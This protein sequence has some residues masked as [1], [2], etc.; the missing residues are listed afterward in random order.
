MVKNNNNKK[1][2]NIKI[3]SSF[4]TLSA[5]HPGIHL[6]FRIHHAWTF[7]NLMGIAEY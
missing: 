2:M 3:K 5:R 4:L 6:K 7:Y 1:I